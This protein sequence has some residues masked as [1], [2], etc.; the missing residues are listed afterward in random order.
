MFRTSRLLLR[1]VVLGVTSR[2]A[3]RRLAIAASAVCAIGAIAVFHANSIAR[4]VEDAGFLAQGLGLFGESSHSARP[5]ID[6]LEETWRV[7]EHH[8]LLGVGI[9][10]LPVD[11]ARQNDRGIL[12]LQ[13]AKA[14]Q[15]MSIS[16]ELLASTGIIGGAI[17]LG[18]AV[19]IIRDLRLIKQRGNDRITGSLLAIGW[20]IIWM[21]GIL[22]F[23]QN[24]LRIYLFTDLGVLLACI[25]ILKHAMRVPAPATADRSTSPRF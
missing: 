22:Q 4:S 3:V 2:I 17:A 18:F 16:V 7:F 11:I 5:R 6:R 19:A 14:Y 1:A 24:F 15:G 21:L 25:S 10:A 9:G 20:G 13:Q 8:P 12:N 23:N